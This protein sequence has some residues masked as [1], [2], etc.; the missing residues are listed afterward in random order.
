MGRGL[1]AGFVPVPPRG[2]PLLPRKN[3]QELKVFAV[4]RGEILKTKFMEPRE[5]ALMRWQT[6]RI[7]RA[8]MR[9]SAETEPSA[10]TLRFAWKHFGLYRR[11][12]GSIF[13][14]TTTSGLQRAAESAERSNLGRRLIAANSPALARVQPGTA[15]LTSG[16]R[17][18]RC[19]PRRD[20]RHQRVGD[21]ASI[22]RRFFLRSMP[23]R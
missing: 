6:R 5:R 13:R 14:T 22:S 20:V 21:A 3:D 7:F 15:D 9:S 4:H 8:S 16:S 12:F 1:A 23:Q 17:E 18:R 2:H 10:P 19:R 11:N